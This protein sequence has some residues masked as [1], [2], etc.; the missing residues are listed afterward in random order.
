MHSFFLVFSIVEE[1]IHFFSF[2]RQMRTNK[3]VFL[4]SFNSSGTHIFVFLRFVPQN[5]SFV[6]FVGV[7]KRQD[8]PNSLSLRSSNVR[9]TTNTY[10]Q[11]CRHT[12]PTDTDR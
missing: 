4:C 10:R 6:F 3:L 12:R 11:A 8:K 5:L 7:K 1:Q 2:R 9:T